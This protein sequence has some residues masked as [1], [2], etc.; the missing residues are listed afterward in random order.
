MQTIFYI[1]HNDNSGVFLVTREKQ[2]DLFKHLGE[3][4]MPYGQ[5]IY[6]N[7]YPDIFNV[8]AYISKCYRFLNLHIVTNF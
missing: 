2:S 8:F 7:E 5:V 3:Y 1:L 4:N 6:P